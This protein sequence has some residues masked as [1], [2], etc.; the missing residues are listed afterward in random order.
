MWNLHVYITRGSSP[1]MFH[2]GETAFG[3]MHRIL[4]P[5]LQLLLQTDSM[6]L[7]KHAS[8]GPLFHGALQELN[9]PHINE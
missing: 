4:F 1:R 2:V 9:L 3:I 8:C 6:T 7:I 5:V